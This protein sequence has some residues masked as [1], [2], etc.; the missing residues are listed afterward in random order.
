MK[1]IEIN[2]NEILTLLKINNSYDLYFSTSY[3]SVETKML[4]SRTNLDV[5]NDFCIRNFNIEF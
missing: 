4:F 1:V 3:N 5:I 2:S